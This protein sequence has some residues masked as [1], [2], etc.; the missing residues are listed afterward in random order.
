MD[1]KALVER[2][3][4]KLFQRDANFPDGVNERSITH[5]LAIYIEEE[6]RALGEGFQHLAVDCEYN[7]RFGD[8]ET[9]KLIGMY[10]QGDGGTTDTEATTVYPD[11]VVHR[12]GDDD[13]NRIIIE[14]KVRGRPGGANR[15]K[16]DRIKLVLYRLQLKYQ[17]AFFV[18][19]DMTSKN[20]SIDVPCG[21]M[22]PEDPYSPCLLEQGHQSQH[23]WKQ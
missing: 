2:A 9:K 15:V 14:V 16:H 13:D 21:S 5:R 22:L 20:S 11:I 17:H 10:G 8:G 6:L 1:A 18:L 23:D 7:R 4:Q 19:L 3:V 12:R